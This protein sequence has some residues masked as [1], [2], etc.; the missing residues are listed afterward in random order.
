MADATKETMD[1]RWKVT[2]RWLNLMSHTGEAFS[3]LRPI[4]RDPVRANWGGMERKSG[5][6]FSSNWGSGVCVVGEGSMLG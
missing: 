1:G 5:A 4:R 3:L 2:D 6:K